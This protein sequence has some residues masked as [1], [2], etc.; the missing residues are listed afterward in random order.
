MNTLVRAAGETVEFIF[1]I[2][3][4]ATP[5]NNPVVGESPTVAVRRASD[6]KWWDWVAEAWDTVATYAALGAEHKASMAD[7]DG[8]YSVEFDQS[9]IDGGLA[10]TYVVVYEVPAGDYRTMQH[11]VWVFTGMSE[12]LTIADPPAPS[13]GDLCRLYAHVFYVDGTSAGA[14]VGAGEGQLR[15]KEVRTS[16]TP[17]YAAAAEWEDTDVNGLVYVDVVQSTR[18]ELTL[19][20]PDAT[21][22]VKLTVPRET[23]YDVG[24][25]FED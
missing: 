25:L 17:V 21:K 19:V 18:V 10:R 2:T 1:S 16:G 9:A 13:A 7:D 15:V 6:D 4:T 24:A 14:P 11:E 3:D 22:T 8:T 23:T 20:R 12:R 5:A